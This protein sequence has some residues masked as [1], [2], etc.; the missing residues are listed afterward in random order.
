LTNSLLV[1]ILQQNAT[2][3]GAD[4][5]K[6]ISNISTSAVQAQS[7]LLG[8]LSLTLFV[9][10]VAVLGKQ[11]ILYY[12]RATTWGNTANPGEE[13]QT[14]L[15]GLQK[16]KLELVM[17]FLPVVLQLAL[18]LFAAALVVYLWDLN[19]TVPG[20]VLGVTLFGTAFYACIIILAIIYSDCPFQT[21]LSARLQ[22][23]ALWVGGLPALARPR[24]K[25]EAA[26]LRPKVER[27]T[28]HN[29]L[30]NPVERMFT[31]LT[32]G[33]NT[34]NDAGEGTPNDYDPVTLSDP[35]LWRSDPLF[36]YPVREDVA[37]SAGFW[38]LE[39]SASS[40]AASAVTAVF[41]KLQWPSCHPLGIT[42]LVRLLNVYVECVQAPDFKQ[43][44][45][46][47]LKALQYAAAYYVLYHTQFIWDASIRL[48]GG[49]GKL[50]PR[51]PPDLLHLHYD[52]WDG[53]DVFEHLLHLRRGRGGVFEHL[54][55]IKDRSE[56]FMSG[57][58]LAH[59]APYWVCGD[60]D[61]AMKFRPKRLETLSTLIEVLE[62]SQ[63][64]NPITLTDC[65]LSVG[66]AVDFP[67]HPDDL[68]RIDKRCVPFPTC[69][70]RV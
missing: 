46:T 47:Y 21:P 17:E 13:R 23:L 20:V 66:V 69:R 26:L 30:K 55:H 8:S 5:L 33:M 9:A 62:E 40:S 65:I 61:G 70:Y 12:T 15:M 56:P 43:S 32:G 18:L 39:N 42:A 45:Y 36:A 60:S 35:T 41:F 48:E 53:D 50:P 44:P 4:P 38:L 6:P 28:E 54:L 22:N 27:M 57:Q 16:W 29:F 67:L 58:F 25:K 14:K 68:I 34:A 37:A 1:R 11:W 3:N 64:L 31:K 49:V 24:L 2:F 63:M 7:I 10:F 19:A 51:L 52:E 59:I